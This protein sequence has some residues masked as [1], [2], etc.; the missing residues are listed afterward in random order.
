MLCLTDIYWSLQ[1]HCHNQSY[2]H[3]R[4]QHRVV[5]PLFIHEVQVRTST[6]NGLRYLKSCVTFLW[7]S[8]LNSAINQ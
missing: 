2:I 6:R 7:R 1:L 8:A 3:F 5:T 4:N